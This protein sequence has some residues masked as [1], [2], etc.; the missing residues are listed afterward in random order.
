MQSTSGPSM[1][2]PRQTRTY[3]LSYYQDKE[4]L[5][6]QAQ[7]CILDVHVPSGRT[8]GV[9]IYESELLFSDEL[10]S[11]EG[12]VCSRCST[13]TAF[14][15]PSRSTMRD[16]AF[17]WRPST[18]IPCRS[19]ILGLGAFLMGIRLRRQVSDVAS[20]GKLYS[21]LMDIIVRFARA[22]LIHGD[23]NEFNI[24]I[25]KDSGEPV[26]IDFPQMVSTSHE[27]AEW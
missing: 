3:L 18:P 2:V 23:Y 19:W 4:G 1:S 17:S 10:C 9:G 20:P 27:N 22:G 6:R 7:V 26:V 12:A 8:K 16:T 13:N 25:R 15:F 24:L 21:M 14:Q 5:P 11:L